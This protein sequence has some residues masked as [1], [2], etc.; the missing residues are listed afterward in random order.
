MSDQAQGLRALADQARRDQSG[1]S[2]YPA[3]VPE[4]TS[5]NHSAHSADIHP[6][7]S[8]PTTPVVESG[9][10]LA[11]ARL[12]W[13]G[14]DETAR[15]KAARPRARVIAVT[16]G[17]G[18]VG[19]TNFSTN[20]ALTL[21][22][23]GQRV[24][25]IDADLGLANLHVVLG[26]APSYHLEHVM[27]GEKS[28][29]EI[30]Y[31]GPG[32]IQVIGGGSGITELANL[33]EQTRRRFVTGL[34]ELDSLADIILIDTGAGL[35]RNVLAFL[36]AVEEI[37]VLTTPEPT[38]IT[39]AYATI[40]VV[41]Q[42]NRRARVML[43]V[44]MAQSEAEAEAVANKIRLISL[45]FLGRDLDILGSIPQ[46]PAV[47]RAVRAQQPFALSQPQSAATRSVG[48]IAAQLGY[49]PASARPHGGVSGFLDQMQ[50]F[51]GFRAQGSRS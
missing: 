10:A 22:R 24:I 12:H 41:S 44:N 7:A 26:I 1:P 37:V 29:R 35:S 45:Q 2:P 23:A 3:C 28:L 49:Q 31:P 5:T 39:D 50:R 13:P 20:L 33:D 25:V 15:Q 18:G 46:D 34:H 17:K 6:F 11:D 27:R 38:A 42:E 14:A 9:M 43:V 8:S 51:F 48:Q 4:D 16:S 36:C 40:K 21:A 30:L 32:G 47:A 19:K